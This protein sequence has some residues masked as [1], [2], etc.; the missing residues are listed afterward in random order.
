VQRKRAFVLCSATVRDNTGGIKAE[1]SLTEGEPELHAHERVV[2]AH[3][4]RCVGVGRKIQNREGCV[5]HRDL[6]L[7]K[8]AQCQGRAD[9]AG[10]LGQATLQRAGEEMNLA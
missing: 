9:H 1:T 8:G 6:E 5:F 10:G 3:S 2:E 4:G 7:G